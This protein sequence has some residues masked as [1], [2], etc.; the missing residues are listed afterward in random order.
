MLYACNKFHNVKCA[1]ASKLLNNHENI[2]VQ[3]WPSYPRILVRRAHK[4]LQES[5]S[6]SA[7]GAYCPPYLRPSVIGWARRDYA[8]TLKECLISI[9]EELNQG[10]QYAR[11]ASTPAISPAQMVEVARDY[12]T[13]ERLANVQHDVAWSGAFNMLRAVGQALQHRQ[14]RNELE[15]LPV[16]FVVAEVLKKHKW[17]HN[18]VHEIP[19]RRQ[20]S[21]FRTLSS[22]TCQSAVH[23][24]SKA[25]LTS[26]AGQICKRRGAYF[27]TACGH[28]IHKHCLG[29]VC[30]FEL[31]LF[32]CC[33][34][35]HSGFVVKVPHP[36]HP[37]GDICA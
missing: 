33:S 1:G 9:A 20:I 37:A 12:L 2:L 21:L 28:A 25:Q 13:Q 5:I 29:Q 8:V 32:L 10:S 27:E 22:G 14:T 35:Y 31:H 24:A 36:V 26:P 7:D 6:S 18:L 34:D 23:S 30:A 4:Q 11:L 3:Q 16:L 15:L 19:V 17:M